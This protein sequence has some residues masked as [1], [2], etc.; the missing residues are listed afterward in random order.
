MCALK[1]ELLQVG[2]SISQGS[3]PQISLRLVVVEQ[4][5]LLYWLTGLPWKMFFRDVSQ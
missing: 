1:G 3:A 4:L 5:L 2:N